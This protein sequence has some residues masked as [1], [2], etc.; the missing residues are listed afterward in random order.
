MQGA[1]AGTGNAGPV[2]GGLRGDQITFK[3][4]N[5]EYSGRV[6]GNTIEGTMK[7]GSQ[8]SKWTATRGG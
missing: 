8:S 4:G 1:I 2:S 6:S 5:A 3:A 7:S